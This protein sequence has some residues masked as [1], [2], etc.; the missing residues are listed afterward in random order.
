[1]TAATRILVVSLAGSADRRA[2][3]AERACHAGIEWEFFDACRGLASDL[4]LDEQ[5]VMLHVGRPL[6]PAELG[7]YA[8]H[9]SIW[10]RLL[11]DDAA[12]Y[13]VL[14]DDVIADWSMLRVIAG[15]DFA[16]SVIDYMRL[17]YKT[18]ASFRVRQRHFLTRTS[19]LIELTSVGYGTQGYV[20]TRAGAARLVPR[21]RRVTR[22][23]DD[24]L[25]RFWEH[26][27]PNLALFPFPIIEEAQASTIGEER[28]SGRKRSVRRKLYN[29]QDRVRRQV[30][31]ARR[32]L[33]RQDWTPRPMARDASKD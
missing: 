12:Q 18:A 13:I 33:H 11:A 14:E 10:Q 30:G 7:C 27:V 28:F 22:P 6:K 16:A 17:Y 2:L 4:E 32:A 3:F 25:D 19:A 1:M 9:Y 24:Q 31:R 15:V 5:A 8:S 20:I 26:G 21:F 23:V 29:L